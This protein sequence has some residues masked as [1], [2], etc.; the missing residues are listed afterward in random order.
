MEI[1]LL[2]DDLKE[3][4]RGHRLGWERLKG[5][6]SIEETREAVCNRARGPYNRRKATTYY[7][8]HGTRD[9]CRSTR[10]HI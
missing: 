2:L 7:E 3:R 9:A 6:F 5:G 8:R 4:A 10:L 1:Q